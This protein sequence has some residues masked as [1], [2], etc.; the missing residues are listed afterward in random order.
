MT[1]Q[2]KW[3][4]SENCC[5]GRKTGDIRERGFSAL[6]SHVKCMLNFPK[7]KEVKLSRLKPPSMFDLFFPISKILD[8]SWGLPHVKRIKKELVPS[9]TLFLSRDGED[10]VGNVRWF[11]PSTLID[12]ARDLP[13]V[14]TAWQIHL[15]TEAN[16]CIANALEHPGIDLWICKNQGS[17]MTNASYQPPPQPFTQLSLTENQT[18]IYHTHTQ[19]NIKNISHCCNCNESLRSPLPHPQ[20]PQH[21]SKSNWG[22]YR[23][24]GVRVQKGYNSLSH[25]SK[26][27][28]T[29]WG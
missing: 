12:V 15:P 17:E 11:Q 2:T 28:N 5:S 9:G 27:L 10:D 13:P 14:G 24:P 23:N 4:V 21:P 29:Q 18:K 1:G 7:R 16:L 22:G 25:I 8:L 20:T 3:C 6:Q 26:F 19:R